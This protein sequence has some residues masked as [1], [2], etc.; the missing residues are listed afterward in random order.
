MTPDTGCSM[1][2]Y[3]IR[4]GFECRRRTML[5]AQA[6]GELGVRIKVL[7]EKMAEYRN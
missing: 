6:V 5:I 4:G 3:N 2:W 7:F 1:A